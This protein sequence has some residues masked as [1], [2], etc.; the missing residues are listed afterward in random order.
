MLPVAVHQH[1]NGSVPAVT[2]RARNGCPLWLDPQRPVLPVHEDLLR[3]GVR[4][5]Q[6]HLDR[7]PGVASDVPDDLQPALR[8]GDLGHWLFRRQLPA[9]PVGHVNPDV[10]EHPGGGRPG[11][12]PPYSAAA[13]GSTRAA[14]SEQ[15]W[16]QALE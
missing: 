1:A 16:L 2:A 11:G 9:A 14:A 12:G 3:P 8:H 13:P 10:G 5:P 6:V 15:G 7:P 4:R